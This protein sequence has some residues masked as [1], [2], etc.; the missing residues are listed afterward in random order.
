MSVWLL[1]FSG[2]RNEPCQTGALGQS[3]FRTRGRS[4]KRRLYRQVSA[5]SL[6][7]SNVVAHIQ[8]ENARRV[9]QAHRV[10]KKTNT[11]STCP[12]CK[13]AMKSHCIATVP[14]L[15]A[16]GIQGLCA[17]AWLISAMKS[18]TI[19]GSSPCFIFTELEFSCSLIQH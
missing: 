16:L 11:M 4:L 5:P 2:S 10:L 18:F 13:G 3:V 15:F 17:A 14:R 19:I 6:L 7:W 1:S 9:L 8:S 12:L